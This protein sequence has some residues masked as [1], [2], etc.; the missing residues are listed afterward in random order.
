MI[1]RSCYKNINCDRTVRYWCF[2]TEGADHAYDLKY[3]M[4]KV[5]TGP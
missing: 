4:Y 5:P 2:K 3:N 1:N